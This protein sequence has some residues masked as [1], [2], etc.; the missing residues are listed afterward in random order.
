MTLHIDIPEETFSSILA[1]AFRN[2]AF[3]TGFVAQSPW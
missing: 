1:T 2:T 3:V